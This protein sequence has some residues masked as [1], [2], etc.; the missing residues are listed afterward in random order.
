[1]FSPAPINLSVVLSGIYFLTKDSGRLFQIEMILFVFV[2]RLFSL[3]IT[4][5]SGLGF[6]HFCM[7]N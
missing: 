3:R 6:F 4:W 7:Y 2:L 5:W 1:M